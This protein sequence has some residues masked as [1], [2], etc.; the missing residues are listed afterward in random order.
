MIYEII[1]FSHHDKV[2]VASQKVSKNNGLSR[3]GGKSQVWKYYILKFHGTNHQGEGEV[4]L[5]YR[6]RDVFHIILWFFQN[7]A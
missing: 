3:K 1:K 2:V 6:L 5:Y 4:C 7:S